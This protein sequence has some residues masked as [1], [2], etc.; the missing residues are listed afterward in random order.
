MKKLKP[1]WQLADRSKKYKEY[2]VI[3]YPIQRMA[4]QAQV[5]QSHLKKALTRPIFF[6]GHT[7]D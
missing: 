4:H 1:F 2:L 3:S 6:V 7:K 5:D